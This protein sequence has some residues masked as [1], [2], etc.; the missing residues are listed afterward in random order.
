[1]PLWPFKKRRRSGIKDEASQPLTEKAQPVKSLGT[2]TP[3]G[4]TQP[5]PIPGRSSKRNSLRSKPNTLHKDKPAELSEK[6]N[7][8]PST[9]HR[10]GS[11]EDITAL[12]LSKQL[13]SSPHLRPVNA[14]KPPIPYNFRGYSESQ[15]S[16]QRDK[17]VGSPQRPQTLRS[18][19][20]GYDSGTPSRQ[21]SSKR[22]KDDQLREE[23]IRAMSAQ[24]PMPKR[25][26]GF[27]EGP[28][29]R[30]SKKMRGLGS[31]ESNISLPAEDSV[32]SNMSA[33]VEQRGWEIGHFDVFNPRPAVRLSGTPQYITSSSLPP[34]S[35][36]PLSP[37]SS[38][39]KDKEKMPVTR[40]S[41]KKRETIGN[42][43]DDLDASDIRM[44][45]ERDAKRREKKKK[46]QQ[47]K[48]DK[49][50]RS[51][52]GRNRGDSDKKRREAEEPR[53]AEEA[54]QRAEQERERAEEESRARDCTT[55]PTAIHPALRD[56]P[57]EEEKAGPV[58]LGIGEGQAAA[59][60][61]D[62]KDGLRDTFATPDEQPDDPFTDEAAVE[63]ATTPVPEQ[64]PEMPGAFSPLQTPMEDPVLETAREIRMSQAATPPLSPVHSNRMGSSLPQALDPRRASDQPTPPPPIHDSRR[65]SDPK[66]ER[67]AGAW[68]TFFR[69]G[70]TNLRKPQEAIETPSEK[71]FSNTS[72]ES[73]RNQPLPPHLVDTQM[74]SRRKS[75]TPVRTQSR[76]REDLPEM[77]ISPPD[78]RL[79]SPDVTTAA[80][81]AAAAR[82]A[83]RSQPLVEDTT[84][85]ES[86]TQGSGRN[87]TPMSPSARSHRMVSMGSVDSE[88]SWF[89][90]GAK[91]HSAQ[92]ALNQRR[93]D[94][95]ASYEEL[96]GDNDAE[97]VNRTSASPALH[98]RKISSP[99]LTGP[100]PE[101]ESEEDESGLV[102]QPETP[103]D[104]M[105]VHESVRR[106]PTLVHRD[107]RVKSREGLLAEY[108]AEAE[109]T[110]AGT[111]K[112]SLDLDMLADEPD[113]SV[114]QRASSIDY[115]KRH[116]RQMSA[117][118]AKLFDVP[119][120]RPSMDAKP[121]TP[122]TPQTPAPSSRL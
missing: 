4:P 33:I 48:L 73:M 104:P 56:A 3:A 88:G 17:G 55:P 62:S 85:G 40:D 31:K 96:G 99:A 120:R 112:G 118:S 84:M 43:A 61:R 20:S 27:S 110:S 69:R 26:G 117:G 39:K 54:R 93:P 94:F 49:K 37:E 108:T 103:G 107:P 13:E 44:L 57:P 5:M 9:S 86:E 60:A 74:H 42:R 35:P 16:I 63:R 67:R 121:S 97:Y 12:P 91:R 21:Q 100:D 75:G 46:E 78:S 28:L 32:Y 11:R 23:E 109:P 52:G 116:A 113:S 41:A 29:R 83:G 71:S 106:K 70:G 89:A 22:K 119:A 19:R 50:L 59:G 115:G 34:S 92:S 105:T 1:M 98:G 76:F 101:E 95:S 90:S 51:R 30:E 81:A 82:R 14:E 102:N 80:A 18:R 58:G 47:E 10:R 68:A 36:S 64:L 65:S 122:T 53:R 45:L 66:P 87:D 38:V 111:G 7:V 8:P 77:P 24:V 25:S 15:T 2:T 6:E 114:M 72:R 79:P